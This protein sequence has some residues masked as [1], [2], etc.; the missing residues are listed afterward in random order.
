VKKKVNL[1]AK[2][3]LFVTGSS[4]LQ[5]K[6]FKG[7]NEVAKILSENPGMTLDVDGHTDNVGNDDKNMV[8]SQNRA[9]AVKKYL[10]SKGVAAE[11]ITATGHGETMPVADNKTAV[12][13]QQNRR[14]ELL[15]SYFK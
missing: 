1:A 3:I 9:D 11:R 14:S 6:S 15:L 5:S 13:R 7:L 4:K 8:L 10:V 2:N 12:G